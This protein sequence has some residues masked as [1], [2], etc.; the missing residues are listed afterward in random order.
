MIDLDFEERAE[1]MSIC[2]KC[3]G[4]VEFVDYLANDHYCN[5]CNDAPPEFPH[6]SPS[7]FPIYCPADRLRT[8][9][10]I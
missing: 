4:P 10:T 2:I 3:L 1:K 7:H 9:G 8:N 6:S 5:S